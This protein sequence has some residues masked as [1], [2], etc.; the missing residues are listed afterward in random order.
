MA[1]GQGS[2]DGEVGGKVDARAL[3]DV[4]EGGQAGMGEAFVCHAGDCR[5]GDGGTPP[6]FA[7][8]AGGNAFVAGEDATEGGAGV[9]ADAKG[10]L[11][12]AEGSVPE[13]GLGLVDTPRGE[14]A[15]GGLAG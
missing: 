2:G 9:V 11:L 8:G 7:P 1:G 3:V 5:S 15:Q 13:Q 6:V 4:V 14:V 10:D 12:H